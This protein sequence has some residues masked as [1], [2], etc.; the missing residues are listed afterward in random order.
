MHSAARTL[1]DPTPSRTAFGVL[2]RLPLRPGD[3]DAGGYLSLVAAPA[4]IEA[5]LH[6]WLAEGLAAAHPAVAP[7][8]ALPVC[9]DMTFRRAG[10][11]RFPAEATVGLRLTRLTLSSARLEAALFAPDSEALAVTGTLR[12]G[13]L[14]PATRRPVPVPQP[15]REV[16]GGL[17]GPGSAVGGLFAMPA[18]AG[19]TPLG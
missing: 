6:G 7:P 1:D 11:L 2:R 9:D 14:D 13:F 18:P 5:A 16:L 10:D 8:F 4:L 15:L 12:L 3:C 19:R 17:A